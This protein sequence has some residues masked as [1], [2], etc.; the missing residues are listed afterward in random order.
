M[1]R[2]A[3]ICGVTGQDGSYLAELLLSKGYEVWGTSR[4]AT[5][6]NQG[7]LD[8]VGVTDRVRLLSMAASDFRSVFVAIDTS[9]PDEVYY[10]AGQTSVGLSFGMPAETLESVTTGVLNVL[11]AIRIRG[12]PCRLYNA[13]SSECF[14]ETP[15][16]GATEDSPFRPRS[17]YAVAKSSA[18]WLVANYREAYGIHASTGVLFNHE[19]PLRPKKFVT[20]KIIAGALA[21]ARGEASELNLGVLDV[22]RDWGWAPEYV[23]AM[24]LML[25]QDQPDDYVIATGRPYSLEDFVRE[26]FA[27]HGLD[28]RRHVHLDNRFTRPSDISFS[29]GDPSKARD[30]L[31]WSATRAMPDVVRLMSDA[32]FEAAAGRRRTQKR[33]SDQ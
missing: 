5:A 15:Q 33:A 2:R 17:P 12:K 16:D 29:C 21:I 9:D 13:G 8:A 7:G 23:V 1:K 24:W 28:W 18:H 26:A 32:A 19:S 4:D 20:Q 27:V 3:L 25:Q 14:G 30:R 10:L 6:P 11:E 31:G 22:M